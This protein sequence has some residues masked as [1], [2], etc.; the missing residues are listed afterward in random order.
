ML[1]FFTKANTL[2]METV[3]F[4]L[5]VFMSLG[6]EVANSNN[7]LTKYVSGMSIVGLVIVKVGAVKLAILPN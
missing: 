3:L 7:S 4:Q 5:S 6:S 2:Y 1:T